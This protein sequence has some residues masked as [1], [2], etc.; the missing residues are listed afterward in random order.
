MP[1]DLQPTLKSEM[2]ELR[3]LLSDDFEA[4]CVLCAVPQSVRSNSGWNCL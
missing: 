4:R 2:L 1:F 3:P